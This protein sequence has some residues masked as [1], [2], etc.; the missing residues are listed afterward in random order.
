MWQAE[1]YG[2]QPRVTLTGR[3]SLDVASG[4]TVDHVTF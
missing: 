1:G 3:R 4:D 2:E